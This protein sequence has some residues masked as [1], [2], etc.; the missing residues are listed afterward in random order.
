MNHTSGLSAKRKAHDDHGEGTS[1]CDS[2]RPGFKA[3]QNVNAAI[4]II[5]QL[6]EQ[7]GD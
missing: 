5:E 7:E 6:R 4:E 2:R 1:K 3:L